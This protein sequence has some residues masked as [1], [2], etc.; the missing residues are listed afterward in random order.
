MSVPLVGWIE[1]ADSGT[2]AGWMAFIDGR[3]VVDA[4]DLV[5]WLAQDA[6]HAVTLL[7][8]AVDQRLT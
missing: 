8:V 1:L 7:L 4:A 3:A 5:P 6:D 2:G